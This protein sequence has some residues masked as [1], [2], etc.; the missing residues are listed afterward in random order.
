MKGAFS[1]DTA[2]KRKRIL[3]FVLAFRQRKVASTH[4][5]HELTTSTYFLT[6][7]R[8][9]LFSLSLWKS[10]LTLFKALS[11]QRRK[12][13][14]RWFHHENATIFSFHTTTE[15]FGNATIAG[16]LDL[17][18]SKTQQIAWWLWRHRSSSLF[19]EFRFQNVFRQHEIKKLVFLI[20]SGLKSVF[21]KLRF[22]AE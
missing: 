22:Y 1:V 13:F 17:C 5:G 3:E 19:K 6:V 18:L 2:E 20:S 8:S 21:Q 10:K 9:W 12:N 16:H 7:M 14:K 11:I 4:V 15:E